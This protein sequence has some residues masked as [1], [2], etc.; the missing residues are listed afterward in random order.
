MPQEMNPTMGSI[1]K[2]MLAE[3]DNYNENA[4]RIKKI[5]KYLTGLVVGLLGILLI[6][7]MYKLY[8]N[9]VSTK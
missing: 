7:S 9:R 6:V 5:N 8:S 3:I 2:N 1:A 4:N